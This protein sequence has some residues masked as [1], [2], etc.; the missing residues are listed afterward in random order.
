MSPWIRGKYRR[1]ISQVQ[2]RG[3]VEGGG[4]ESENWIASGCKELIKKPPKKSQPAE[5]HGI[6]RIAKSKARRLPRLAANSF[7][8]IFN[9]T[10][11]SA[12]VILG[13]KAEE[14]VTQENAAHSSLSISQASITQKRR[15][16]MTW[17]LGTSSGTGD[18]CD[19][20]RR[21][22]NSRM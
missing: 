18:N 21:R 16:R 20:K 9:A 11:D 13:R 17:E 19:L 15:R 4:R 10:F 6:S 12:T 3:Q 7:D 22:E 2:T 1:V 14:H 8:A 5:E